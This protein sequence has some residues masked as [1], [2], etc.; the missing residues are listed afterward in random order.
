MNQKQAVFP[1]GNDTSTGAY[2]PGVAVGEQV[3]VSGQGPLDPSSGTFV[4]GEIEQ[5]TRLTLQNVERVLRSA[6]CTLD[7]CVKVTVHL[8]DIGD[9]QRFN[10][11][12]ARCFARP[13]PARTTVQSVLAEGIGIEI[14]AIAIRGSGGA[15]RSGGQG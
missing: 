11:E 1:G 4:L 2:S 12:Y 15:G 6:G 14:D 8:R 5:Q 3:F 10:A 7:D 9:F 13:F